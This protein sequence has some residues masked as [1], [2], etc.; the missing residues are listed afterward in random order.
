MEILGAF[1]TTSQGQLT[2]AISKLEVFKQFEY[3]YDFRL[4]K[5]HFSAKSALS[6]LP[7]IA[8]KGF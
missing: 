6:L 4:K 7:V 1:S 8:L 3:F 5:C 2:I